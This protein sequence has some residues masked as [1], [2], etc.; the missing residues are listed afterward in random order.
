MR[1][2]A[3]PVL[4]FA[5]AAR[6]EVPSSYIG[7]SV[8]LVNGLA[9]ASELGFAVQATPLAYLELE[10]SLIRHE[11]DGD[12]FADDDGDRDTWLA[13]GAARARLPL[14]HGALLAGVGLTGGEHGVRNGCQARGFI[15]FCGDRNDTLVYRRWR[16][17]LWLRPELAAEV[18]IGP[19][20]ARLA[21]AP[22]VRLGAPD[23]ER[24]CLECEDGEQG[25]L[26]TLGLHGR[27]PVPVRRLPDRGR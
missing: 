6:A 17:A 19:V 3:L 27:L 14:R 1:M 12:P 4:L 20:A 25:V 7:A 15:D 11:V 13:G 24:G 16:R 26:F 23:M 9:G 2:A 5:L 22:L 10:A 8:E 21:V 18:G